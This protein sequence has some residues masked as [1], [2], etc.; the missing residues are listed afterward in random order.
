MARK[1][2]LLSL[3]I[4]IVAP[5]VIGLFNACTSSTAGDD[6]QAFYKAQSQFYF[7]QMNHLK[8]QV[9]YEPG[10][11]PYTGTTPGGL[12]YWDILEQNLAAVFQGRSVVFSIPKSLPA[13]TAL[14]SQNKNVWT[15]SD[16]VALASQHQTPNTDSSTGAFFVAFVKGYAADSGGNPNPNVIGFSVTGTTTILM[17]K[18]VIKSTGGAL[19]IVPKYVEQSTLVHEMGHAVGFV[20]N[21][22]PTTSNHH[23][24]PHGAHCSNSNCV[25]HYL[26]EGASDMKTFVQQ[27]ITSGSTVMFGNECLAD[28]QNY[29]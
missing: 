20:N 13:M 26:N 29:K 19:A 14:P 10:A 21:G 6:S 27:Y 2:I 1:R 11:E 18:D 15:P 24:S 25:M 7:T 12:N 8:M 3:V 5:I 16:A 9:A 22:L 28:S 23:D 17:F 4:L